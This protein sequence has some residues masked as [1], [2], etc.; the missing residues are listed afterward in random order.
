MAVMLYSWIRDGLADSRGE[1]FKNYEGLKK[2]LLKIAKDN[3]LEDLVEEFYG[4]LLPSDKLSELEDKIMEEYDD[5][6]FWHELTTRLGKRDFWRTI[7]P[8]EKQEIK[9]QNWLPERIHE[10]YEKYEKEFEEH[11]L[12]RIKIDEEQK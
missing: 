4:D 5:D 8:K 12:D 11:G 6:T 3:G 9:K 2:Y 10:I 7:T 1:D